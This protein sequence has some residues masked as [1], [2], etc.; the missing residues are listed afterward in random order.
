MKGRGGGRTATYLNEILD[1]GER[2]WNLFE[3]NDGEMTS[4]VQKLS[5]FR[6]YSTCVHFSTDTYYFNTKRISF[7]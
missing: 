3:I 5:V 2:Y 1:V 6:M 4:V 7:I